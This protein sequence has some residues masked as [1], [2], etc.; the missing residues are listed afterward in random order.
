MLLQH[1]DNRAEQQRLTKINA[2]CISTPVNP[3]SVL[4]AAF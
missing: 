4:R 1:L 2:Q 3:G